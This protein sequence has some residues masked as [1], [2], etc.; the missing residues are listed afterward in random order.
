MEL[1]ATAT[2]MNYNGVYKMKT[3][4]PEK[5][6]LLAKGVY[7]DNI[8]FESLTHI[9]D[10]TIKIVKATKLKALKDLIDA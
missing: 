3:K 9:V 2:G 7:V 5:Y 8:D 6:T 10:A 4:T 1:V